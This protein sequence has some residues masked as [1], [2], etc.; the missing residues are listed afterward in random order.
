MTSLEYC[1]CI[2]CRKEFSTKG[3]HTHFI[4]RHTSTGESRYIMSEYTR[5]SL[6]TS[7][8]AH[9]DTKKKRDE[10]Q[11]AESPRSCEFCDQILPFSKRNNR[12]CDRSC[13][14]SHSNTNYSKPKPSQSR[15]QKTSSSMRKFLETERG[16]E[17]TQNKYRK[18][19]HIAYCEV[20][21]RTHHK[22]GAKHIPRTCSKMCWVKLVSEIARNDPSRG[23]TS[24]SKRYQKLDSFGN[25]CFLDSSYELK[26][27]NILDDLLISWRRP[28]YVN[29][30]DADG[31]KRRYTADFYLPKYNIYLDPKNDYL[32]IRCWDKIDAVH[33]DNPDVIVAIL[34]SKSLNQKFIEELLLFFQLN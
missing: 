19:S 18:F 8:R 23:G 20:C 22:N 34:D 11:Y 13:S 4:R 16:I 6:S 32:L 24:H 25:M 15:R 7:T 33:R 10:Q 12:F 21:G 14:A 3:I 28:K 26:L 2:I 5:Q 17:A 31:I 27:A 9:F 1:S 30:I 29:Y